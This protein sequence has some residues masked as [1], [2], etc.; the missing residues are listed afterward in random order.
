MLFWVALRKELLEQW[1]SYCALLFAAVLVSFWLL[2]PLTAKFTPEL[3]RV[4]PNGDQIAALIPPA[5]I[6]DAVAQYLKNMNQF[7][8]ILAL[9]LTMG[10][11]TQ[12]KERGTAAMMLSKPLPRWMFLTAKFAALGLIFA[13]SLALA[14]LGAYY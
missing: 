7:A 12:E 4:L 14:G 5:T 9:L 10:A 3:L 6:Q 2:S 11:V 1:R 8:V 13:A